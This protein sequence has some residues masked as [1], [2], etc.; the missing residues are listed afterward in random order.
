MNHE[1][2]PPGSL[3][4]RQKEQTREMIIDALLQA[5]ANGDYEAMSHDALA[6]R[7]GVSRQTIYRYFPDRD[8]LLQALWAK[9]TATAGP[10]VSMP[11]SEQDIIDRMQDTY[12]GFDK[13]A[14]VMT[15]TL[16][17]PH[18][19]AMRQS[20][21]AVRQDRYRA[22]LHD[23][24]ADLP[25]RDQVLAISVIQLLSAGYAWLEMRSQWDMS[26]EEIAVACRWAAKTLLADLKRR[27]GRRL[28]EDEL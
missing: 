5:M 20:M 17:T 21:K 22:I 9:I 1:I 23:A 11:D 25:E 10:R 13:I 12:A 14:N 18:G 15:V 2:K 3:R 16:S 6:K 28:S 7:V 19:R 8:A 27:N 26:G 4:E 24:V